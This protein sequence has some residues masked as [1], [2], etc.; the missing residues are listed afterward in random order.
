MNRKRGSAASIETAS[1]DDLCVN[2][3]RSRMLGVLASEFSNGPN[4]VDSWPVTLPVM[5]RE[6]DIIEIYLGQLIEGMLKG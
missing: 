4:V 1:N 5:E 2:A 3:D 6:L